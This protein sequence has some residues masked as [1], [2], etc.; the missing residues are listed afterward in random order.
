MRYSLH[1]CG[2][3]TLGRSEQYFY[4]W[5]T[6][7]DSVRTD[8]DIN[9]SGATSSVSW[10]TVQRAIENYRQYTASVSAFD[11][12][13][14][15]YPDMDNLFVGNAASVSGVTVIANYGPDGQ[16]SFGSSL[17]SPQ[18]V[19]AKWEDLGIQGSS[20]SSMCGLG[21]KTRVKGAAPGRPK[22]FI[23]IQP[24]E[25]LVHLYETPVHREDSTTTTREARLK[26][27]KE[28]RVETAFDMSEP[29]EMP[30][31]LEG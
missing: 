6:N 22:C 28:W 26:L 3:W 7:V 13:L 17:T 4:I 9:N 25:P 5:E 21:K 27:S 11:T 29:K 14:T 31:D 12:T 10:G 16:D 8:R 1:E 24:S 19:T 18:T 20:K 23:S 2:P 30:P 15:I